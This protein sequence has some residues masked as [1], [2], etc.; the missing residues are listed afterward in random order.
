M[1]NERTFVMIKPDGV[2]RSI[3][4]K[5]IER[6]EACGLKLVALKLTVASAKKVEE[7]YPS[8]KEWLESIGKKTK[9]GYAKTGKN[10]KEDFGTEVD[11][12]IGKTVKGWLIK[13]ITSGPVIQMVWEGERAVEV[14]RKMVGNTEP[15]SANPGTIRSDFTIETYEWANREG[16]SVMNTIHASANIEEA[17]FEIK[18]WF[19]DNELVSY[20]TGTELV[21][22]LIKKSK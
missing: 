18:H 20:K 3:S 13:Y 12:D 17:T 14:V 11:V 5:I 9:T 4:G 22:D 21:L 1:V 15:I 19:N 8:S 10:V 7:F 2:L 16:R 6:F